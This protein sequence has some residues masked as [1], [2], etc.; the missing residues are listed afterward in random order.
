ML[1]EV[2]KPVPDLKRCEYVM[3]ETLSG[4]FNVSLQVTYVT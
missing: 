4:K 2:L 1:Y 3:L